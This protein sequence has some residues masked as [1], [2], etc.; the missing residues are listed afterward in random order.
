MFTPEKRGGKHRKTI[1]AA[2]QIPV[3]ICRPYKDIR[4]LYPRLHPVPI[5]TTERTL[6][7]RSAW[8]KGK[9]R[10][11]RHHHICSGQSI[12]RV[13]VFF[14]RDMFGAINLEKWIV[15][16]QTDIDGG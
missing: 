15:A 14:C 7:I 11:R 10:L 12:Y 13:P 2:V 6:S 3:G 9:Q 16:I 1:L 4:H 5:A 8:R